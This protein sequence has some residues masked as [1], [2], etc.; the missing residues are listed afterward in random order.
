MKLFLTSERG[1]QIVNAVF[2]LVAIL[3]VFSQY[4][5]LVFYG[6]WIVYLRNCIRET[7]SP[8]FKNIYKVFLVFAFAMILMNVF[9]ITN[10]L[11]ELF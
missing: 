9:V 3:M 2:F 6:A 11:L 7:T 5:G 10:P 1:M 8:V 4:R